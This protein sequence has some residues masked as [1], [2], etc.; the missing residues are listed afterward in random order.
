MRTD[1]AAAAGLGPLFERQ[2]GSA[3][4]EEQQEWRGDG[5]TLPYLRP[6]AAIG[7]KDLD[8]FSC[9]CSGADGGLLSQIESAHPLGC[10]TI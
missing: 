9:H 3:H 1:T 6:P 8:A 2:R 5:A 10:A 4:T 7:A